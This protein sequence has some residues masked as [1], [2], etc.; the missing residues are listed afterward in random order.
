MDAG[1]KLIIIKSILINNVIL[2]HLWDMLIETDYI[3]K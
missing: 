3:N 1:I 2:K